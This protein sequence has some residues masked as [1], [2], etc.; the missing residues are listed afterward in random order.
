VFEVVLKKRVLLLRFNGFVQ[1][2]ETFRVNFGFLFTKRG[3]SAENNK[4]Q[5]IDDAITITVSIFF[6]N[7][8]YIKNCL[9]VIYLKT[10]NL[11]CYKYA[12]KFFSL[13]LFISL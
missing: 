13:I 12:P 6:L 5:I 2:M 10:L 3:V 1:V 4:R 8:F 11:S 9:R 7:F